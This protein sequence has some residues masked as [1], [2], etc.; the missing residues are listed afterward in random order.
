MPRR[1]SGLVRFLRVTIVLAILMV[2]AVLAL[3]AL[4]SM[5]WMRTRIERQASEAVGAKVAIGRVAFGWFSGLEIEDVA[6]AN[7]PG[8]ASEARLFEMKALR[9]DADVFGLLRGRFSLTGAIEGL[10]LRI[11]QRADGT[12]NLGE[13]LGVR[14]EGPIAMPPRDAG[15]GARGEPI[16]FAGL[17]LDLAIRDA[18]IEVV[19]ETHGVLERL[20]H[21]EASVAKA[22]GT[23]RVRLDFACD[24]AR[25]AGGAPGRLELRVDAQTDPEQPIDARLRAVDLDLARYR[26]VLATF[27]P[28]DQVTAFAGVVTA[29]AQLTGHPG[30]RLDVTGNVEIA[31]PH[32]AGPL[33]LDLDLGAPRFSL[34]P[35]F[36]IAQGGT[37]GPSQID[38]SQLSADL[39]FLSLRGLPTA[40]AEGAAPSAG[41]AFALDVAALAARGGAVPT[42]F[43][44]SGTRLDG[45]LRVPLGA[46]FDWAALD[47]GGF[48]EL[49]GLLGLRATLG[50]KSLEIGGQT[51]GGV[52]AEL[53][54]AGGRLE[55]LAKSGTYG[56]GP[57]QF[58]L[59][60]D[61][62]RLDTL[63]V[64]LSLGVDGAKIGA[65]ALRALQYVFPLAAGAGL[66]DAVP[67]ALA[68]R[69]DLRVE[70][71]GP[72]R[73][74]PD[75]T[76]LA[77]LE[78]W[79]GKG[80]F[81]VTE[82]KLRPAAALSQLLS[83]TGE[84]GEL[85]IQSFANE[86]ELDAGAILARRG[87]LSAKGRQFAL[88]GRTSLA[89]GLDWVLDVKSLLAEHKDG[90]RILEFIGDAPIGAALTGTLTAPAFAL[91]PLDEIAKQ[92]LQ[93]AI[94]RGAGDLIQKE[95]GKLLDS[96]LGGRRDEGVKSVLDGLLPKPGTRDGTPN[97]APPNAPNTPIDAARSTLET[98]LQQAPGAANPTNP[99]AGA[100]GPTR[101]RPDPIGD[102]LRQVMERKQREAQQQQQQQQQQQGQSPPRRDG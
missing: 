22:F 85:S 44:D 78:R 16:D 21:V 11:Q 10:S 86:F 89:G 99:P 9:G 97:Q 57:L 62:N 54:L 5:D 29:N 70:L 55:L 77:W 94:E 75:S 100:T 93:K 24:L 12:T 38:L 65:E 17:R 42:M 1:R 43:K 14:V 39:G 98:I 31:E 33:F 4:L 19:H 73:P 48:D 3:P 61:V 87:L 53:G 41:F 74:A 84:T 27:L 58:S 92:A 13:L 36:S 45:E 96:L 66:A 71:A 101:P 15:G 95:A 32:F 26:P 102:M 69:M 72:G 68:G 51:L 76:A 2:V 8:F 67:V 59:A 64:E 6:V 52:Q 50:V 91:P 28:A 83:L 40:I 35:K 46:E 7:P 37:A 18:F 23:N 20:E 63:P 47:Q 81:G 34:A 90:R 88:S 79:S 30:G 56:D 25:P 82:G 60:A 49:L 80:R